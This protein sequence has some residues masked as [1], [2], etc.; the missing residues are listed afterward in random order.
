M[1]WHAH[2][3][4][5][6]PCRVSIAARLSRTL[7]R[8]DKRGDC[9]FNLFDSDWRQFTEDLNINQQNIKLCNENGAFY[10]PW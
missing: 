7:Q 1:D 2:L 6:Q 10:I 4:K 3:P 5:S 8:F 9:Q